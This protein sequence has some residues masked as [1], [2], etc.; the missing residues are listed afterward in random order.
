MEWIRNVILNVHSLQYPIIGGK[1]TKL[2]YSDNFL[3]IVI[4]AVKL[5]VDT[6]KGQI[7][8]VFLTNIFPYD[9]SKKKILFIILALFL[10]PCI[11]LF[12]F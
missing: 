11:F 8:F 3:C 9:F 5:L 1:K 12:F 10:I 6:V 2:L 4:F 7:V